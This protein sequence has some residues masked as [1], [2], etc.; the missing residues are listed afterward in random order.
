MVGICFVQDRDWTEYWR[1]MFKKVTV[2]DIESFA[3]VYRHSDEERA[4]LRQA[5]IDGQGIIIV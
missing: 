2:K 5:Y 1:A 3:N 4:D